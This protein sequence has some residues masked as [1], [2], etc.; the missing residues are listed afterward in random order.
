MTLQAKL[1]RGGSWILNPRYCRSA[2]RN[3]LQPDYANGLV[4]F[5]VVC[6]SEQK[7]DVAVFKS[8]RG[9]SWN[10]IPRYCRSAYRG[11]TRPGVASLNVGFRVVCLSELDH[12]LSKSQ[13]VSVTTH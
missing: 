11:R 10:S 12:R 3:H 2:F 8:V 6:L 9:G 1:L 7:K 5:R 13:S 4:G